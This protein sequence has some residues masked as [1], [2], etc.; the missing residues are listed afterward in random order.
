MNSVGAPESADVTT[1]VKSLLVMKISLEAPKMEQLCMVC[2]FFTFL[3]KVVK[4]I[5]FL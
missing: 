1:I 3:I 5:F 2:I 4:R